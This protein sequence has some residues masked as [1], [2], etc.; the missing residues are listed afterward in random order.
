MTIQWASRWAHSDTDWSHTRTLL[1]TCG[2]FKIEHAHYTVR[3]MTDV[4]RAMHLVDVDA[5]P[6][7][8]ANGGIAGKTWVILSRHRTLNAAERAIHEFARDFKTALKQLATPVK[9][10]QPRRAPP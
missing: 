2:R 4:F 7:P 10:V 8:S 9:P 3:G 6:R 5:T 1:A